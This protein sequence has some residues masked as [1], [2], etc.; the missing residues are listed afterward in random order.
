MAARCSAEAV[1]AAIDKLAVQ[2]QVSIASVNGPKSVVV[3]GAEAEVLMVMREL[4]Q[5]GKRLSVSHAFHS[6]LMMPMAEEFR[7]VVTWLSE[8]GGAV[9][10]RSTDP[11]GEHG[12]GQRGFCRRAGRSRALGAASVVAGAVLGRVGGGAGP[13]V[14]RSIQAM[15]GAGGR[16]EPGVESH[17]PS[18]GGCRACGSVVRFARP[19]VEG[20][21][22]R[23]RSRRRPRLWTSTST[24]SHSAQLPR[25]GLPQPQGLPVAGATAPAPA[26]HAGDRGRRRDQ[27]QG[28]VP[29]RPHG[30][31]H[32]PH[33]PR[34][35]F[36]PGAGFVEMAL[37]AA[38]L[39][40]SGG[41]MS[42]AAVTLHEVAFREPLDLEVGSALVCEVPAD[43]RDVEFR[44]AGEPD[45]VV[46]SV[47]QVSH[48]SSLGSTPPSSLSEART[49]V[50]REVLGISE[51]YADLRGARLPWTP[52]PDAVAGVAE[53]ERRRGRGQASR[54]RRA[55]ERAIPRAPG[56]AGRRVPARGLLRS[57]TGSQWQGMGACRHQVTQDGP[58]VAPDASRPARFGLGR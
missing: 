29:R 6:P 34:A 33:D 28:G 9:E 25:L 18:L 56:G 35:V 48:E 40:R 43:G 36:V 16:A 14:R 31:V 2:A 7:A 19:A 52:V 46:C 27:A 42:N 41:Q 22:R 58:G 23:R 8:S 51:R 3:A 30:P 17:G 57:G 49:R 38:A 44:P 26:A 15:R 20:R 39:V 45:H 1:T 47:G 50:W 12:D 24:S 11:S 32:G 55:V 5:E 4:G 13:V 10:R 54:A 53:R 37:A 21:R